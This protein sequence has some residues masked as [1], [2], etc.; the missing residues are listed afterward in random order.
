MAGLETAG[1]ADREPA[2]TDGRAGGCGTCRP[3]AGPTDGRAIRARI[4]DAGQAA[5]R[6]PAH[7]EAE[8]LAALPWAEAAR[9]MA[10]LPVAKAARV[11]AAG[12]VLADRA[13]RLR[14]TDLAR[15]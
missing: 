9:V 13:E 5:L 7:G 1:L 12:P 4:T 14:T 8:L 3:R 11:W 2:P 6:S 15:R 10:A